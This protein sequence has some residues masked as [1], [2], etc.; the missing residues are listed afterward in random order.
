MLIT[1][2]MYGRSAPWRLNFSL[3]LSHLGRV[4]ALC[5]RYRRPNY[6]RCLA[7]RTKPQF[8]EIVNEIYK[9]IG[10]CLLR[11][12]TVR[13][14]A[15]AL[16]RLCETLCYS[17]QARQ[18][19]VVGNMAYPTAGFIDGN[20]GT[21][22]FFHMDSVPVGRVGRGA[23]VWYSTSPGEPR[24][25]AFP[26]VPLKAPRKA[27]PKPALRDNRRRILCPLRA[28]VDL[29][30]SELLTKPSRVQWGA[31]ISVPNWSF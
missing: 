11:D 15:D 30:K 4:T 8:A 5:P 21:G 25:R 19:G 29:T 12:P 14:T 18:I 24:P 27:S 16:V 2:L 9:V 20:D 22:A 1:P 6:R 31:A 26:V 10:Q 13:P 28:R 17:V 3:A 7:A 23:R